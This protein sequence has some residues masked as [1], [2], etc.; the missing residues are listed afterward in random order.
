MFSDR[1]NGLI[2]ALH[3]LIALKHIFSSNEK[4][5]GAQKLKLNFAQ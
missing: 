5:S 2:R 4:F 1:G 3:C